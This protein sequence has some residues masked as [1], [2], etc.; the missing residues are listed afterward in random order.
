MKKTLTINLANTVYNIDDDAYQILQNYFE[1]LRVHFKNE[2]DVDEILTDIEARISELFNERLRY[3]MQ[4]ITQKEVQEIISIM[5]NPNEI[6]TQSEEPSSEKEPQPV[7][8]EAQ[9]NEPQAQKIKKRLYRDKENGYIGGVCAGM[10]VYFNI[11]IVYIRLAMVILFLLKIGFPVYV[12]LWIVIPKAKTTAQ[13]LEMR[14]DEPT[15][16]NIKNFVKENVERA[17]EKAEKEFNSDRTKSFFQQIGEGIM[18][19]IQLIAKIVTAF[20]GGVF[21]C[22]GLAIILLIIGIL[23]FSMPFIFSGVNSSYFPFWTNIYIEGINMGN[24]AMYPQFVTG[25][26]IFIGIPLG[27]IAYAIFQKLFNWKKTSM[28]AGWI[29]V[30]IWLISF[31]VTSYYGFHY[32]NEIFMLNSATL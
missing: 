20:I 10:S 7:N 19:L 2:K 9:D 13:K 17:T 31:A 25:L 18:R 5:G 24:L 8:T 29:L 22:L 27:A 32:A 14:G 30:I 15:I 21:G 26:L 11:D 23:M 12:I 3:G 28:T 16:E 6:E 4:V 1:G